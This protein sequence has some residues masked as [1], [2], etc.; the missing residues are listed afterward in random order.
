MGHT[1]FA[2]LSSKQ[3]K[4]IIMKNPMTVDA[5]ISLLQ[6]FPSIIIPTIDP[7]QLQTTDLGISMSTSNETT[8]HEY[9]ISYEKGGIYEREG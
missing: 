1:K 9:T 6:T 3:A 5:F 7:T 8:E 4:S 2:I